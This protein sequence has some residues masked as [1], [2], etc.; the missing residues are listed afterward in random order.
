MTHFGEF[1]GIFQ[2]KLLN[3]VKTLQVTFLSVD[4]FCPEVW[5]VLLFSGIISKNPG[6]QENSSLLLA[7]F[8]SLRH[9]FSLCSE[10]CS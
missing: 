9:Q 6:N 7:L 3:S 8:L 5:W 1:S 4:K 10:V 2:W